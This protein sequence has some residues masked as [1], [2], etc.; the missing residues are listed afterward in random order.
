M[1][2]KSNILIVKKKIEIKFDQLLKKLKK[3]EYERI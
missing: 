3:K 1:K 2:I